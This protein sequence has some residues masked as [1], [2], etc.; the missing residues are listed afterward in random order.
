MYCNDKLGLFRYYQ[1]ISII[2]APKHITTFFVQ[3]HGYSKLFTKNKILS[4][5][6]YKSN[7][8]IN[9]QVYIYLLI[10]NEK[11]IIYRI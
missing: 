4:R 8:G 2:R 6:F 5:Y 9:R 10:N 3:N 1:R 7:I 11:I